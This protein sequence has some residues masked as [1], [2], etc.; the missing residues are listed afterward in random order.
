VDTTKKPVTHQGDLAELPRAL[1]P[2]IERPQWCIWRWT[3][4]NGGGWQKPPFM[5]TQPQRHASMNDPSTWSDYSTALAA[6][7]AGKGDGITYVLTADDPFAAIDLDHCRHVD[8][9][10]IDVW[11]QNF[12]DVARN[13]YSEVTPSGDGIRI[14]GLANGLPVNRKFTLE[15]DGKMIA[16]ELFRRS[17][18]PLTITGYTLD[19]TIKEL[20]NIDKALDWAVVWGERRKAAADEAAAKVKAANGGF[21]SNGSSYTVEQIDTMICD[22]APPGIDRSAVFHA[23]VGHLMGCGWDAGRIYERL[24]QYPNGIGAKYIAEGRLTSEIDRSLKKFQAK[25]LP[26]SSGN[27]GWVNSREAKVPPQPDPELEDDAELDENSGAPPWEDSEPPEDDSEPRS[28]EPDPELDDPELEDDP[29]FDPNYDPEL[30]DDDETPAA[31]LKLPPLF[32]HGDPD[33]RPIKAWLIKHLIPACGHGLL[34]GQW[35]AGK[36]FVAFDLAAALGTGQPFVGHTVKRQCGVLLIAA[37]GGDEVRLRLDAVVREK[38]GN[39]ERAPFRWYETA[40]LLL[41]KGSAETLI[42]MARQ[43]EQ[44]LQEEFG[45]PLGLIIIDTIAACAGFTRAGEENDNAVGQAIMNALK[46]VAQAIDCFV[47]GVDHF[48]KD[49]QAGTRGAFAK[50]SSGD[51]VLVCLGNKELSGAVAN[52]RLAVRKNR[53]GQQG[54]EHPF[55][56]RIVEAPEPDEDGAPI[57]TMVVDWL[58]P[59]AA[60][61]ASGAPSPP[62]PWLEGCHREDQRVGMSRFKRV[63]MAALAEHG[64]DR[65][66]PSTLRV[67]TSSPPIGG[68]TV[69]GSVDAPDQ[70]VPSAAAGPTVRMVAQEIVREA[71]YLC[72]PEDSRQTQHIRFTRARDRAEHR[73][74]IRAGNISGVT[75]LWLTRPN[76]EPAGEEDLGPAAHWTD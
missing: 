13:S 17:N 36:T 14:W 37:E 24:A 54:R 12:L 1:A 41:Q 60:G 58:P 57:T 10:S 43:A 18:K 70:P 26:L 55:T 42:A 35:G 44:S 16:A 47:L 64:V 67:N 62:D 46:A 65:E 75:F 34:S 66:I 69:D 2:L 56:L 73:G 40:P 15:I 29:E 28:A 25:Q 48:G 23:I 20:S 9:H 68:P 72:T 39:M 53:G 21:N 3:Q 76:P 33:S 49:V 38:C 7:Q 59:G 27:G 32:A 22:G 51:V 6:V 61:A 31:D 71:F 8:T 63:L 11:A 5:A 52:T 4:K 19:P 30:D 45:L 74:L 50:E